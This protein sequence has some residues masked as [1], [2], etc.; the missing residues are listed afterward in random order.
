MREL[1]NPYESPL[2]IEDVRDREM[3]E[4]SGLVT[5]CM[6]VA[7]GLVGAGC[8][9]ITEPERLDMIKEYIARYFS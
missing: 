3:K 9:Y 2:V 6:G 1:V 4:E 7:A 5:A 8:I